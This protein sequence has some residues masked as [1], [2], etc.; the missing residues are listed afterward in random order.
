LLFAAL[1]MVLVMVENEQ[2]MFWDSLG[3]DCGVTSKQ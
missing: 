1:A 2:A 3:L